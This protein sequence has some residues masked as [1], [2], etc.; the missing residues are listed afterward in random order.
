M[1][2]YIDIYIFGGQEANYI[3]L[4]LVS[5][6]VKPLAVKIQIR[7]GEL[8]LVR[9]ESCSCRCHIAPIAALSHLQ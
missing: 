8:E 6:H 1:Y 4:R 2:I 3:Y 9:F 7:F 5:S